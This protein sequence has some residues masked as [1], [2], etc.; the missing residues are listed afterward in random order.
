MDSKKKKDGTKDGPDLHLLSV[1]EVKGLL[2]ISKS[3]TYELI[4]SGAL[5]AFRVGAARGKS[6]GGSLRV[7]ARSVLGY[8]ES[9]RVV[10]VQAQGAK[11]E[12]GTWS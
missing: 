4:Q 12:E 7:S 2:N 3:K 8:L 10:P 11:R 9:V 5:E 6:R 1:T